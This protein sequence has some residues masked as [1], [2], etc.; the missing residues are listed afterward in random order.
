MSA[1]VVKSVAVH[2]QPSG[3]EKPRVIVTEHVPVT[4]LLNLPAHDPP[5]AAVKLHPEIDCVPV[6]KGGTDCATFVSHPDNTF[7]PVELCR[8][9]QSAGVLFLK[10][11]LACW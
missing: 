2:R 10:F 6:A 5:L 9:V 1:A 3:A 7:A 8:F 11:K 4:P